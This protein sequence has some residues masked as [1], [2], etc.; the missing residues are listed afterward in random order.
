MFYFLNF[1]V[2][3]PKLIIHIWKEQGNQVTSNRTIRENMLRNKMIILITFYCKFLFYLYI[4]DSVL[5]GWMNLPFEFFLNKLY[6]GFMI[7]V[8]FIPQMIYNYFYVEFY[9]TNPNYAV[10]TF[11][12]FYVQGRTTFDK[13]KPKLIVVLFYFIETIN[14]I[15]LLF[16]FYKE[17]NFLHFKPNK[18][19]QRLMYVIAFIEL[20]VLSAQTVFSST[21]ND[22]S[23]S[24]RI[25]LKVNVPKYYNYIRNIKDLQLLKIDI[26]FYSCSICLNGF[27]FYGQRKLSYDNNIRIC[28]LIGYTFYQFKDD[29]KILRSS[30]LGRKFKRV[31]CFIMETPCKHYFHYKCLKKWMNIKKVCPD[32]RRDLPPYHP[33]N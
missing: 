13:H 4:I 23:L 17:N 22:R 20:L 33:R 26:S 6:I 30:K 5:L 11:D 32:C 2:V 15:Y 3:Q 21:F 18:S 9:I 12:Y 10:D 1:S 7:V 27:R 31:R 24:S 8:S 16:H 14:H 28:P 29:M 19:Y 25:G